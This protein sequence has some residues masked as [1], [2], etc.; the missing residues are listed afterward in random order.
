[1]K[2]TGTGSHILYYQ[3]QGFKNISGPPESQDWLKNHNVFY[4]YFGGGG[5][6]ALWNAEPSGCR[7]FM[8]SNFSEIIMTRNLI[9]K[10]IKA[11]IFPHSHRIPGDRHVRR[12]QRSKRLAIAHNFMTALLFTPLR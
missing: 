9:K 4:M 2:H 11:E 7:Q 6:F 8:F 5:L 3:P 12:T 10:I 1:M